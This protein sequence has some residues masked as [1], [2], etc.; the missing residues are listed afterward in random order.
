[1]SV[2][3]QCV[4]KQNPLLLPCNHIDHRKTLPLDVLISCVLRDLH[5][6]YEIGFISLFVHICLHW[7][8]DTAR[9]PYIP[10]MR[11]F[12]YNALWQWNKVGFIC[13]R[14]HKKAVESNHGKILRNSNFN[15][16]NAKIWPIC[17]GF[18]SFLPSSSTL[19]TFWIEKM[20]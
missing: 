3:I 18:E 14:S 11:D 13:G 16:F 20:F 12:S 1:M 4:P 6:I 8:E 9:H 17:A 15:F 10:P 19:L 5:E 7:Q 2:L